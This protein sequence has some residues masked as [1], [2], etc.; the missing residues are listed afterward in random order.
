MAKVILGTI[1]RFQQENP[2]VMVA[3][4]ME[5]RPFG[6]HAADMHESR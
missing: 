5:G 6:F 1:R 2:H 4:L 3:A